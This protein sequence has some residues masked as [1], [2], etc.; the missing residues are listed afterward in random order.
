MRMWSLKMSYCTV[1]T[2]ILVMMT[3]TGIVTYCLAPMDPLMICQE[4]DHLFP[5]HSLPQVTEAMEMK[6]WIRGDYC[7]SNIFSAN[8]LSSLSE[9]L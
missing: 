4:E 8:F 1:L 9:V 2:L 3:N 7:I 5:D 6:P